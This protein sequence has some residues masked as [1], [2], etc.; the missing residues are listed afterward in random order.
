MAQIPVRIT[1]R[2]SKAMRLNSYKRW[3]RQ[4]ISTG[5]LIQVKILRSGSPVS[6]ITPRC[7][8]INARSVAKP[9]VASALNAEIG[10]NN[11]DIC[12]I[13][14]TWLTEKIQSSLICPNGYTF[15]RKDR[16]AGRHGGGV[17]ML[18]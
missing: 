1:S 16:S 5:N 11:V 6:K 9:D 13:S 4:S 3:S 7:L 14:E 15:L 10:T 17:A 12:I 8:I 2:K 18:C